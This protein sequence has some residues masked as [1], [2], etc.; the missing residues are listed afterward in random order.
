MGSRHGWEPVRSVAIVVGPS[1][2]SSVTRDHVRTHAT[3]GIARA[4]GH[5]RAAAEERARLDDLEHL[6]SSTAL[7][8]QRTA[9]NRAVVQ[10]VERRG[11]PTA[12]RQPKG[13]R[14]AGPSL[15][16]RP[17]DITGT[18]SSWI[19]DDLDQRF[20]DAATLANV[21]AIPSVT[22]LAADAIQ[23]LSTDAD[24]TAAKPGLIRVPKLQKG[25]IATVRFIDAA[26]TIRS[27]IPVTK[28]GALPTLALI[29]TP[30]ALQQDRVG[31][32]ATI[33]HEME[34]ARHFQL[35]IDWLVK[36]RKD[37]P[38]SDFRQWLRARKLGD[39]TN[40]LLAAAFGERQ[41]SEIIANI[42][43]MVAALDSLPASPDSRLLAKGEYPKAIGEL[44]EVGMKG[45]LVTSSASRPHAIERLR[46]FCCGSSSRKA[47]LQAWLEV[48]LD[49]AKLSPKPT[50]QVLTLVKND[51]GS[52][53][54]STDGQKAIRKF[55][56][57]VKAALAKPC[58]K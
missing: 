5:A 46:T 56:V 20:S 6:S 43:G 26:G 53:A 33:R 7:G 8:L 24:G 29:L 42:E 22:S 21:D 27:N 36:W 2:R 45:Y 30:A 39:E 19:S 57:D 1:S 18:V 41:G 15:R 47:A 12:Q 55:L 34:H 31:T 54:T 51:F 58:T 35:A 11:P 50:D 37:A 32:V 16:A 28:D 14:S 52:G 44:K 4:A 13:R 25:G 17:A 3:G 49:P 40:A 23:S 10:L 38:D 9:G 48:L